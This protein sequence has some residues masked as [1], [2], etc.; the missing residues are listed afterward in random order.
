[1]VGEGA[2]IPLLLALAGSGVVK[3]VLKN[4]QSEWHDC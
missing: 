1:M 4:K 2:A 3:Q